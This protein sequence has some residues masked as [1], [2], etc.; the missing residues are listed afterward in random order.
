MA[1][2]NVFD[3]GD[4]E[5]RIV[6]QWDGSVVPESEWGSFGVTS[7]EV[8][9]S[10]LITV[11]GGLDHE[12]RIE[13]VPSFGPVAARVR[14]GQ[15]HDDGGYIFSTYVEDDGFPVESVEL[16]NGP[17]SPDPAEMNAGEMEWRQAGVLHMVRGDG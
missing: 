3:I 10:G 2:V 7:I 14:T 8:G 17:Y 1:W 4:C 5:V 16:S 13:V 6:D 9:A 11:T 15:F 12:I